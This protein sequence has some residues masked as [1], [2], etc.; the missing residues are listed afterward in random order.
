MQ[1]IA[2]VLLL[3]LVWGAG[4]FVTIAPLFG[5]DPMLIFMLIHL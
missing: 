4:I 1:F 2:Q 5:I 3:G